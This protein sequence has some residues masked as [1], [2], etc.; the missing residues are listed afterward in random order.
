MHGRQ[1]GD[2]VSSSAATQIHGAEHVPCA[3][4][5]LLSTVAAAAVGFLDRAGELPAALAA[6]EAVSLAVVAGAD[7]LALGHPK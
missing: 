6:A 3:L 5:F 7:N 1:L 4:F 2:L